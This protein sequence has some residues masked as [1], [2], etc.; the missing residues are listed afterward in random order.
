[1]SQDTKEPRHKKTQKNK[2]EP[3]R[4]KRTKNKETMSTGA[5]FSFVPRESGRI[6][7]SEETNIP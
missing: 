3:R 7:A 5:L 4:H 1:M 6:S 2:E